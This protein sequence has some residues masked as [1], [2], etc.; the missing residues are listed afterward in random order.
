DDTI[1]EGMAKQILD[2]PMGRQSRGPSEFYIDD[3]LRIGKEYKTDCAIYSGHMGC[4]H[5][6]A[7]A[8]LMK[9]IIEKELGIPCLTFEVDCIDSRPVTAREVKRKLKL[10]LKSVV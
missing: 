6:H 3:L 9:E 2:T 8:A 5:S 7:M 10:F 4:K 1:F